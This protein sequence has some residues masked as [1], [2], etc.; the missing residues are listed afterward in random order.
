MVDECVEK[1]RLNASKHGSSID[2]YILIINLLIDAAEVADIATHFRLDSQKKSIAID[3]LSFVV[4]SFARCHRRLY[5]WRCDGHKS[6]LNLFPFKCCAQ[7][8]HHSLRKIHMCLDRGL[9]C[10]SDI[11]N[12]RALFRVFVKLL[13]L[14]C[15]H[16]HRATVAKAVEVCHR[17]SLFLLHSFWFGFRRARDMLIRASHSKR[18]D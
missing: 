14:R 10:M 4:D 8:L 12:Y 9:R 13:A 2:V 7:S 1:Y 11:Q 15:C 5:L 18:W 3:G 6:N 16:C 17:V